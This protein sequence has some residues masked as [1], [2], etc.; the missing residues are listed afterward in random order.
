VTGLEDDLEIIT[1]IVRNLFDEYHG[2]VTPMLSAH[3]VAQWDSLMNVQFLVLIEQAFGIRFS[4]R[5]VGQ[6]KN[7]GEL[8][9]TLKT[10]R[11]QK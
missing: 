1:K 2:P 4:S 5:E 3:D 7:V 10:R 8:M 6:I 11:A 9:A